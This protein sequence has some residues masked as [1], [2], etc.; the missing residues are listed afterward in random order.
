MKMWIGRTLKGNL[1]LFET[2]PTKGDVSFVYEGQSM[3]INPDL[4]PEV[5]FENSPIEV[6]LV[7]N[8]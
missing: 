8:K 4:Y 6:E 7:I 5:T 3:K 2:K 1:W